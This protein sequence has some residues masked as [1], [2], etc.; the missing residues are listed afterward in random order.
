[1][2]AARLPE[3]SGIAVKRA[4]TSPKTEATIALRGGI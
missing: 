4:R 2:H 1:M 3:V